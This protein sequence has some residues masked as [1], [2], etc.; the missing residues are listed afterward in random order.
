VIISGD[1][2]WR[3]EVGTV[4]DPG[5]RFRLVSSAGLEYFFPGGPQPKEDE[6]RSWI[7]SYVGE[8]YGDAMAR[9]LSRAGQNLGWVSPG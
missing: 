5:T 7:E 9:R 8:P 6:L 3:L 2:S 1:D 4:T